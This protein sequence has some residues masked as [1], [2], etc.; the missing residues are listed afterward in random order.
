VWKIQDPLIP[1]E[2]LDNLISK[3][4]KDSS[5]GI[6]FLIKNC[7]QSEICDMERMAERYFWSMWFG[8]QLFKK[9][10]INSTTFTF[11]DIKFYKIGWS[12]FFGKSEKNRTVF[13]P[14]SNNI[15]LRKLFPDEKF[16]IVE[17]DDV[18]MIIV[19]KKDVEEDVEKDEKEDR[20]EQ[21]EKASGQHLIIYFRRERD[22]KIY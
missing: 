22:P 2:N 20:K 11:T 17:V 10:I 8:R 3:S 14:Y 6:N 16:P 21:N 13:I 5:E 12:L 18:D 7:N 1:L 4:D 9:Y 15:R 19:D